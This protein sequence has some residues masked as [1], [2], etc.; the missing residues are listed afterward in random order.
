MIANIRYIACFILFLFIT[1]CGTQA[2]KKE[3]GNIYDSITNDE[4]LYHGQEK[5]AAELDQELIQQ[6]LVQIRNLYFRKNYD[7]A[8]VLAERL[9]RLDAN[10]P[11]AYYWI[12]RVYIQQGDFQQAYNM[13]TKG[14]SVADNSNLKR[15]L[16]RVQRQ[17]QMGNY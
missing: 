7:E 10:L 3:T 6:H 5:S 17:A 9:V 1:A 8:Q 4:I 14:I 12:A 16:E 15:E 13:A 11:E 2:P